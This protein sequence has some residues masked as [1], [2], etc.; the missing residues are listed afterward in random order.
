MKHLFT[1]NKLDDYLENLKGGAKVKDSRNNQNS[2]EQIENE[3]VFDQ[4]EAVFDNILNETSPEEINEINTALNQIFP[5]DGKRVVVKKSTKFDGGLGLFALQRIPDMKIICQLAGKV[6]KTLQSDNDYTAAFVDIQNNNELV[7]INSIDKYSSFGR[8]INDG[9]SK[10]INNAR[11]VW[12][13]ETNTAFVFS[14]RVIKKGEEIFVSYGEKYWEEKKNAQTNPKEKVLENYIKIND[15]SFENKTKKE[16]IEIIKKAENRMKSFKKTDTTKPLKKKQ[17][18]Q[19][20]NVVI[21]DKKK[22]AIASVK[23]LLKNKP[24]ILQ[25][26][27]EKQQPQIEQKAVTVVPQNSKTVTSRLT[28]KQK[29]LDEVEEIEEYLNNMDNIDDVTFFF[30]EMNKLKTKLIGSKKKKK[31]QGEEGQENVKNLQKVNETKEEKR[32][33]ILARRRELYKLKKLQQQPQIRTGKQ[34]R[35]VNIPEQGSIVVPVKQQARKTVPPDIVIKNELKNLNQKLETTKGK[36]R[37]VI[38][39]QIENLKKKLEELEQKKTLNNSDTTNTDK[40]M[41]KGQLVTKKQK[42]DYQRKLKNINYNLK[43]K[44]EMLPPLQGKS[45]A[46]LVREIE[47]L[48]DEKQSL[49]IE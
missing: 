45:R 28:N 4:Y 8:Y 24:F 9:R 36:G 10:E 22:K 29:I 21:I 5:K 11:M 46:S 23:D 37:A 17:S 18:K 6:S 19:I 41:F 20:E 34:P 47:K 31:V 44:I 15:I 3:A 35:E 43:K 16:A 39:H 48:E 7:Y 14:T 40:I 26:Q 38:F 30:N 27:E 49:K 12:N 33:R 1:E 2:N 32:A 42:D 25:K 13:H